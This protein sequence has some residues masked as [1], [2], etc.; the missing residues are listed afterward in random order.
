MLTEQAINFQKPVFFDQDGSIDD[1]I[2]LIVL[3]TFN[4][5]R[6]TGISLTDGNCYIDSASETTLRIL[7]LFNRHDLQLSKSIFSGTHPFP[8]NWR[9]KSNQ[10]ANLDL[11]KKSIPNFSKIS[12]LEAADFTAN[13]I[14]NEQEK[15]TVILTGP[16]SNLADAI[17]KYP[18]IVQKI[19]KIIWVA[20]A[21]L[22][23]GNVI[24]P[25]HDGSAEWNIYWDTVSAS[26]LLKSGIPIYLFP[27][28]VCHQVTIDMFLLFNLEGNKESILSQLCRQLID[29]KDN[30]GQK[31]YFFD[32]LPVMYL[33]YPEIFQFDNTSINI[34]QR[35]TSMGNIFRSSLGSKIKYAKKVDDESFCELLLE[36][37]SLF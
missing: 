19:E 29:F 7:E 4:N 28:D 36:Q 37:T 32:L 6:L 3:L 31:K 34:E 14:L 18:E 35:G 8:D 24:A 23:D 10:I 16:A 26:N 21:F 30:N 20:G 17:S 33:Q 22:T 11:L 9:E 5:F 13:C 12:N 15:T 2:A 1:C 25:D 27:L